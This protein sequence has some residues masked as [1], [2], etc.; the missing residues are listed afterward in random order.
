MACRRR[1]AAAQEFRI[2]TDVY[3]GDEEEPASHTVTLFEKSAVYEFIDNPEQVDR[4]PRRRA[5]GDPGQFI[6][7]DAAIAAPHR[8]RRRARRRS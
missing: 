1:A 2:E 5:K 7:L 3:V 4:L 8:R 6:L